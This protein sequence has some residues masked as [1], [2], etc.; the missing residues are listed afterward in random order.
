MKKIPNW[1]FFLLSYNSSGVVII[2][3]PSD[4]HCF[5]KSSRSRM[6]CVSKYITG[7]TLCVVAAF[8]TAIIGEGRLCPLANQFSVSVTHRS[9]SSCVA[10]AN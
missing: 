6:F 8:L 10:I 5:F 1:G 3:M 7:V 4:S 9:E 2:R